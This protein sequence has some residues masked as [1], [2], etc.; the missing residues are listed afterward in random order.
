MPEEEK[1]GTTAAAWPEFLRPTLC[2]SHPAVS[3]RDGRRV[4]PQMFW[5]YWIAVGEMR[6]ATHDAK[7]MLQVTSHHAQP[8]AG[9]KAACP[10]A[11]TRRMVIPS[12]PKGR[13][14]TAARIRIAVKAGANGV[15]VVPA[16]V[17]DTETISWR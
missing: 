3:K 6:A 9:G 12:A 5:R 13:C 1:Y 4:R 16:K 2:W 15:V 17:D 10:H 11:V 14:W 7:G 8:L